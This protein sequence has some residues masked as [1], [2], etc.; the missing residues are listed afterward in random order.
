MMAIGARRF[1]AREVPLTRDPAVSAVIVK[2][3]DD[4]RE[5]FRGMQRGLVVIGLAGAVAAFLASLW[6]ARALPASSRVG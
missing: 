4:A 2:S 3:R 6:L 1:A 5:P